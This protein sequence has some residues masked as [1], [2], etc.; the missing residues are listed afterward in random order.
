[1]TIMVMLALSTC[2]QTLFGLDGDGGMTR[3]RLLPVPGWQ[4]LAAKDVPFLL[5]SLVMTLPLA[6]SAGLAARALRSGHRPSPFRDPPQQPSALAVLQRHL[7]RYKRFSSGRDVRSRRSGP[8]YSA[9]GAALCGRL[10]VVYVVVRTVAGATAAVASVHL[11]SADS[12]GRA[13]NAIVFTN[14]RLGRLHGKFLE[15]GSCFH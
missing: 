2:A 8:C 4:I 1:M 14:P 11:T 6:P 15:S 9:P 10:C 12:D 7:L 3:Y 13:S 5:A